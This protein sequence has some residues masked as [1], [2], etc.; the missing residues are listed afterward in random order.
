MG[1]ICKTDC[2][3]EVSPGIFKHIIEGQ[4]N[5]TLLD[6]KE[7]IPITLN[8]VKPIARKYFQLSGNDIK[9]DIQDK[10]KIIAALKKRN[11]KIPKGARTSDVAK[12]LAIDNQRHGIANLESLELISKRTH[13]ADK[14]VI[15][16]KAR[17]DELFELSLPHQE[18]PYDDETPLDA[19]LKMIED[20]EAEIAGDDDED[21]SEPEP[22]NGELRSQIT[23]LGG[24]YSAN[25]NKAKLKAILADL[26]AQTDPDGE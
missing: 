11:I 25:D 9:R 18:R 26:E 3:I 2:Q 6:S 24:S 14:G 20:K 13:I 19:L 10:N 17:I 8:D 7:K 5:M 4:T 16:A 15:D 12:L 23:D 21:D 22:T 1:L